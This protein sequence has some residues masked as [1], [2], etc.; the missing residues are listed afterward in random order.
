MCCS[1]WVYWQ[2][3]LD[4]RIPVEPE[5]VVGPAFANITAAQARSPSHPLAAHL[6][7]HLAEAG[8]PGSSKYLPKQPGYAGGS[9]KTACYSTL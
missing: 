2:G 1:P 9:S 3:P 4:K 8:T 5:R 7:I 6:L